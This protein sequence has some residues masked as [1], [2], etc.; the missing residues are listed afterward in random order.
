[1]SLYQKGLLAFA[2]VIFVALVTVALLVGQRTTTEFRQYAVLNSGRAQLLALS[3]EDYFAARGT[4]VGVEELVALD[5][6]TMMG[7]GRGHGGGMGPPHGDWEV[8]VAD[9]GGRV[10]ASTGGNVGQRL[11]ETQIARALPLQVDGV[12][13]GYLI[14]YSEQLVGEVLGVPE[15][16]FLRQL[17]SALLI[18]A[19]GAFSVALLVG[20][21]LVRNIVRPVQALTT[22]AGAV[23]AG[24]LDVRAP[25]AGEDEIGRLGGA[26]NTMAES[27]ER[28]QA[29]RRQQTADIAHEL[30]NPLAV[31]QGTLEAVVDGVYPPTTENL[32]PALD[33]VR[34][35]NR[36]VEDLR[37]LAL[38]DAGELPLERQPL[39]PLPLLRRV[40]EAYRVPMQEQGPAFEVVLPASLPT[41]SADADRLTQVVGNVLGNAVKYVPQEGRVLL[42]ATA[43]EGGVV[44]EVVDDG[45]GLRPEEY[46]H[47]FQRFWRG[48]PSRSRATGGSGLGLAIA[49]WV[50]EAHGGRIWAEPS[51][52]GGLTVAF[53]LPGLPGARS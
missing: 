26:F 25:V 8:D 20:G 11:S 13:V 35:L 19:V 42:R 23:A 29:A 50:I 49:R 15:E 9:A 30:R 43:R 47:L 3:L 32:E 27:L 22:A 51:P 4:W 6:S 16:R 21:L 48:E 17:W 14:P 12:I 40:A 1:M 10:V 36:L 39:D 53:W 37:L 5:A 2:L 28:A 52:G 33:Q 24:D 31:L 7:R 41:V 46:E 34:T 45:P 18:G 38:V 44:V